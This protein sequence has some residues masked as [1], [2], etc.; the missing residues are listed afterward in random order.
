MQTGKVVKLV[1][2]F[3][4]GSSHEIRSILIVQ[5]AELEDAGSYICNVSEG[6]QQNMDMKDITVSVVGA[7]G[8]SLRLLGGADFP[9]PAP[10]TVLGAGT[11][12]AP[13]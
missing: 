8:S 13:C 4:P 7:S 6:F 10:C 1:T 12:P 5:N 11:S 3:L 2:D 9:P